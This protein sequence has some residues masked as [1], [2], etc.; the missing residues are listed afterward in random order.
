M[1]N[2]VLSTM[3]DNFSDHQLTQFSA[4]PTSY[5]HIFAYK[6]GDL[7]QTSVLN[8]WIET[9]GNPIRQAVRRVPLPQRNEIR[10]LLTEMQEKTSFPH[11][12]ALGNPILFLYQRRMILFAFA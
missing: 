3:P 10:R 7:G 6:P 4:L 5:A 2:D 12:K 1:V 8:H 11:Q 9:N